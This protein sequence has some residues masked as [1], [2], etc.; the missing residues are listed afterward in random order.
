MMP[1][2]SQLGASDPRIAAEETVMDVAPELRE[3]E[4][5]GYGESNGSARV[6]VES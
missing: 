4:A 5:E 3:A 6:V 2:A 1:R